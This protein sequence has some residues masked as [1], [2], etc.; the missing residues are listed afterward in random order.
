MGS[1]V[2]IYLFNI[3][4]QLFVEMGARMAF[5][6]SLTNAGTV[7]YNINIIIIKLART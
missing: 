6:V 7:Y 5:A 4:I 2:V 3:I 1:F